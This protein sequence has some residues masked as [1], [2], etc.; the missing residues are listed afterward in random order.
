MQ[1]HCTKAPRML[2]ICHC[3]W[4][5]DFE[6]IWTQA[7]SDSWMLTAYHV[8]NS[9]W[10]FW[11]CKKRHRLRVQF[12][13]WTFLERH[14][15]CWTK[16]HDESVYRPGASLA[17]LISSRHGQVNWLP[18]VLSA[19]FDLNRLSV[20][21]PPRNNP[22]LC[23]FTPARSSSTQSK[24]IYTAFF[25]TWLLRQGFEVSSFWSRDQQ[26]VVLPRPLP[27]S[28]SCW[29]SGGTSQAESKAIASLY[30]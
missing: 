28:S 19:V 2:F 11:L 9:H 24:L 8:T 15:K 17:L 30:T 5:N 1:P 26:L 3:P 7:H 16:K 29:V 21:M 12:E 13:T 27:L 4:W 14:E 6:N 10:S 18:Q 20:T 22:K 25:R 23:S